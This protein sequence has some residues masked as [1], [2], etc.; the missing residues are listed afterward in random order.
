[1]GGYKFRFW[2]IKEGYMKSWEDMFD[3]SNVGMFI[4]GGYPEWYKVMLYAG[5]QDARD[6]EVYEGDICK[7]SSGGQY[8]NGYFSTLDNW[9]L[10]VS[11][12]IKDSS[13]VFRGVDDV[14]IEIPFYEVLQ[15]NFR[16]EVIGNIHENRELTEGAVK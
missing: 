4:G 14:N 2:L 5:V 3:G 6:S 13:F 8:S 16:F 12:V 11:V 1:M 7:L 15:N 10:L 9:E